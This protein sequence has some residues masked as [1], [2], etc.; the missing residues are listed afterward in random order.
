MAAS[1]D[2]GRPLRL[3][4]TPPPA[5]VSSRST[6]SPSTTCRSSTA[7]NAVR[8]VLQPWAGRALLDRLRRPR[9]R[10]R[11]ARLRQ[12]P[13]Q[14]RRSGRSSPRSGRRQGRRLPGLRT[15]SIGTENRPRRTGRGSTLASA[16]PRIRTEPGPWPCPTFRAIRCSSG[17]RRSTRGPALAPTSV[18]RGIWAKREDCNSGLAFGGNKMRKLE[19]LVADA[20][21]QGCD[22]LVSIGG[23][24]R[25]HTR[26]VAAAA[27]HARPEVR[28]GAGELGRLA[29]RGLRPGR[30]HP[31]SAA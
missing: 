20:L 19:Y 22:T 10:R 11:L 27:A 9:L 15:S 26:A 29:R 28:P 3:A 24:S 7:R 23:V 16:D 2:A 8:D 6:G 13:R 1:D 21:A 31:A 5:R 14:G 17:R 18:G 25:N 30:Q 12:R 4:N